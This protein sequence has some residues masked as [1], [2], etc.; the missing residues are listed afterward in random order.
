MGIGIRFLLCP[1]S[2]YLYW[3]KKANNSRYDRTEYISFKCR[4]IEENLI[5][6]TRFI[7]FQHLRKSFKGHAYSFLGPV[8]QS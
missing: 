1:T 4:A 5:K 3:F 6:P 2:H 8:V 7:P